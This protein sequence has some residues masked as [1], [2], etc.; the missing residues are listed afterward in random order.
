MLTWPG[1]LRLGLVQMGIGACVALTTA[2][3]N[4]V[5][6]VELGLL[7]VIP[8]L[9]VALYYGIQLARPYWGHRSDRGGRR[10]PWIVGGFA[11]LAGGVTVAAAAIHLMTIALVPGFALAVLGFAMIGFG[12]GASGTSLLALL[13]ASVRPKDRAASAMTTWLLMIFG[14]VATL[15]VVGIVLDTDV[16]LGPGVPTCTPEVAAAISGQFSTIMLV[17]VVGAVGAL[18]MALTVLAIWGVEAR[19][20]PAPPRPEVPLRTALAETWADPAARTFTLFVALS[21]L[22]FF[23]QELILEPYAGHV[24]CL[25]VGESTQI[26]SLQNG[27]TLIGMISAGA[28]V[29]FLGI[30]RLRQWLVAGCFW[31]A[32]GLLA[33]AAAGQL[34]LPLG[35]SVA[36]MGVGFGIFTVSAVGSMMRLAGEEEGRE[37]T[38]M[39]LWGG[40]QALAAGVGSLFGALLVDLAR[41]VAPLATAYGVVFTLEAALFVAAG[42]LAL[43]LAND[44]VP[45]EAT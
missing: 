10:T 12:S 30:G 14:I 22:A 4:R 11:V 1:I 24:F 37:G 5:M 3:M 27:G 36:V 44:P 17:E 39:G 28:L 9:L 34:Q 32:F 20:T 41:T 40:V 2:L 21:M 13:A 38:R 42:V 26:S 25:N 35:P 33:V 19:L 18:F 15:I 23:M 8:G 29:S 43:S 45:K 6:V 31:A 16:A 7:A